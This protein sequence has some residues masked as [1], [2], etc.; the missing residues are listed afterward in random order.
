MPGKCRQLGPVLAAEMQKVKTLLDW[1][2]DGFIPVLVIDSKASEVYM[3]YVETGV[4]E[5]RSGNFLKTPR[6]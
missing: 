2:S 4:L 6:N 1:W 3:P 5:L